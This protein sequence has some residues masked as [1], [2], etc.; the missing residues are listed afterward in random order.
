MICPMARTYLMDAY[1]GK[2][3]WLQR[4]ISKPKPQTTSWMA[5]LSLTIAPLVCFDMLGIIRILVDGD[6]QVSRLVLVGRRL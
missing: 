4:Q 6:A 5:K 1:Y 2:F 3:F